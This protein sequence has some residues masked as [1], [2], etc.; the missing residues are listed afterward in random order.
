MSCNIALLTQQE[1]DRINC[2]LAAAGVA[3]K[4][5]YAMPVNADQIEREQPPALQAYF[6]EQLVVYRKHSITMSKLPYE[7]KQK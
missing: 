3:F 4:E 2:D 6:R 7:P 5:R 1:K